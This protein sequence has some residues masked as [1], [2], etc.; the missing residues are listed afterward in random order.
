MVRDRLISLLG[1]GSFLVGMSA[2]CDSETPNASAGFNVPPS[3]GTAGDD[4]DD[5]G[6]VTTGADSNGDRPDSGPDDGPDGDPDDGPNSDPDDGP[7]DAPDTEGSDSGV[8][9][10][11][12]SGTDGGATTDGGTT[13]DGGATTDGEGSGDGGVAGDCCEANGTPSCDAQGCA[14]AVCGADPFCCDTQWDD[15]CVDIAAGMAACECGGG[16]AEDAGGGGDCCEAHENVG[17]EVAACE[18]TVCGEDP[19]CCDDQWDEVCSEAAFLE[20]SCGCEGGETEGGTGDPGDGMLV[21]NEVL[22]D[23]P[24]ADVDVFIELAGLPGT[25]LNGV[26]LQAV[27]GNGGAVYQTLDLSGT[28]GASGLYLI[29]DPAAGATLQ[30][31]ADEVDSIA[32]LQNGPD[33]VRL[34]VDDVEV[35]ALGY[36]SFAGAEVFAGEGDAAADINGTQ[37]LSRFGDTDDNATDFVESDATPGAAN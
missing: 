23:H 28:I 4:G 6:S 30:G 24:G 36:G 34:L 15:A 22:Y 11:A 37:S 25:S 16:G 9:D 18:A 3:G 19:F 2:G 31:L 27:N 21:I 10:A 26:S 8:T 12:S 33:S 7:D 5:D 32:D 17:C 20:P 13:T 35:D 29:V 1:A 14:D